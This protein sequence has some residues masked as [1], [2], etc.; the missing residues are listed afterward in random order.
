MSKYEA[1]TGGEGDQTFKGVIKFKKPD[2]SFDYY[3]FEQSY[4]VAKSGATVSADQMNVFYAGVPNPVTAAAAGISPADI[5]VNATGAGVKISSKGAG[6][7]EFTFTGVG[8]CMVSVSAKTKDGVKSQGPPIKFRVKPLPKP[9]VKVGPKFAPSEIKKNEL[10]MVGGLGAG[11]N[12]FDFQANFAVVSYEITGKI[13]GKL[14]QE[15]G[16]GN[17]LSAAAAAIF[18]G[19]DIGTKV[20][21][22]AKVKGPDGKTTST[23]CAI[24]VIK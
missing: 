8:E 2:G 9:E 11:A 17:N 12:G 7:Y 16:N 10:A 13:R 23:T 3:P 14:S 4:K 5:S 22:D 18:K 21:I 1:G 24:K 15:S 6:K 19:A 20:Y